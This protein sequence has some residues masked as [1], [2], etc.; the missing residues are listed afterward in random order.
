MFSF[1]KRRAVPIQ[2][3]TLK[4]RVQNFWS[5]YEEVAPRFSQ[6]IAAGQ[7]PALAAEVSAKIDELLPGFA[8]VFGPGETDKSHSLTL[9]GEG[10]LHRQLVAIYWASQAPKIT[11]WTFYPS[12]QPGTIEGCCINI[13]D[14]KFDPKEFWITPSIN[15][16]NEVVDLIVWHPL[17]AIVPERDRYTVLFL[18]LD[19]ILGEYGTQHWIGKI[20]FDGK[21]LADSIPISELLRFI[22]KVKTEKGWQKYPPGESWTGYSFERQHDDFLRGD[23]IAGSTS[24]IVLINEYL[25]AQ[26]ELENPLAGTG[27]DYVFVAFDATILPKGSEVD[28][29]S[30]IEDALENELKAAQCGRVLGGAFGTRFAYIDVMIFDG[31]NSLAIIKKVLNDHRL[32]SGTTVHFFSKENRNSRIVL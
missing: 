11:S 18:F 3:L 6:T 26:G 30:R 22:E 16:E 20:A 23:I 15:S 19:E 2:P 21:Q 10:N 8:W 9:S 12:R 27:A 25:D 7:C 1:F 13:G 32:P 5:W 29:R 14:R 4:T 24:N 17:L 28:S 31:A